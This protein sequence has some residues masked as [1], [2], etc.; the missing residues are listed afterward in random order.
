LLILFLVYHFHFIFVDFFLAAAG[1]LS[2]I[3]STAN[4][5]SQTAFN[6]AVTCSHQSVLDFMLPDLA[7]SPFHVFLRPELNNHHHRASPQ[8]ITETTP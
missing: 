8:S 2:W 1:I 4:T 7:V 3:L 5:T 6:Q